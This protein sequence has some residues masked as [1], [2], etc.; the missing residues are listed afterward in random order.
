[1]AKN[2][3]QNLTEHLI[4]LSISDWLKIINEYVKGGFYCLFVKV[5]D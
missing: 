3:P 4:N 2:R 1:M 5:N